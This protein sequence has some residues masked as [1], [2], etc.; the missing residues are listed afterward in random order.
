MLTHQ[1]VVKTIQK[2]RATVL[3]LY[4]DRWLNQLAIDNCTK[5][6]LI[7]HMANHTDTVT[8]QQKSSILNSYND[9]AGSP[10][11]ARSV[12]MF[13][14]AFDR[15]FN[16]PSLGDHAVPL[17]EV[18]LL[19]GPV[20]TIVDS[21]KWM[22]E[23]PSQAKVTDEHMTV[24]T[25][26]ETYAALG[27]LICTGSSCE[28]GDYGYDN[29][30]KRFSIEVIG[31]LSPMLRQK[32][33][34][35]A[36]EHGNGGLILR[37]P[38]KPCGEDCF[39]NKRPGTR[40]RGWSE[41]ETMIL[42][43]H[44]MTL[45]NTNI[46]VQCTAALT[47]GR[48]CWDVN[49]QLEKIEFSP[50]INPISSPTSKVKS[51][52]WYDRWKKMLLNDWQEQTNTHEHQRKDHFD[53]CSHDGPC[54]LKNCSCVQNKLMCERFC[55]CTAECC[56]YK[57][58]GCACHSQGKTC[59]S[60]Q[61]DRPCICIQLNRECDPVLCGS[62]GAFERANPLYADS[63]A[64]HATGCQNCA[65]Q[66]GKSKSVVLG[67]S[68]VAGY[69]LYTTEDIAQDDF[70]IE[71]VGEL[72]SHDE[73]VRREARRGDVFDESSNTSYLFTLLEQEGT[74][75]DAAIYGN[76]SRYI[77]HQDSNC[78]VTPRI[79]YVNGEYRIKFS[80]LRDI[81]A[82]EELFFNYGENFPNLTKKLLEEGEVKEK[83]KRGRK[84]V[85]KD[86]PDELEPGQERVKKKPGRKPGKPGRPGR[87]PGR[88]PGRPKGSKTKPKVPVPV[89][90]E[91]EVEATI[92]DFDEDLFPEAE[93]ST[94]RKRK[95][96]HAIQDSEEEEYRPDMGE[97][98]DEIISI[99]AEAPGSRGKPRGRKRLGPGKARKTAWPSQPSKPT[100]QEV[101][102]GLEVVAP[103][104]RG[105]KA[106]KVEQHPQPDQE[107]IH[108]EM[109]V[110][111]RTGHAGA[112][113][114]ILG[115]TEAM[116]A[117]NSDHD[118][119]AKVHE[120]ANE[121][122]NGDDRKSAVEVTPSR[123]NNRR[124]PREILESS[125]LS[126]PMSE[127]EYLISE[128][129][130]QSTS[131]NDRTNVDMGNEE[132]TGESWVDSHGARH[133]GHESDD[134]DDDDE[135]VTPRRRHRRK[136]ARYID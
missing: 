108:G 113:N 104:R 3:L 36:S 129:D 107:V 119:H 117:P 120:K 102:S 106:R 121:D 9:D 5:S 85:I 27:C 111:D 95:R 37:K 19:D 93:A 132:Y 20:D 82:G 40:A 122:N 54:T 25:F 92:E 28:H 13:T 18:L 60:K 133:R 53:P 125:P 2:E 8:P 35:R 17:R 21:K 123:G 59:V 43:S 64:L 15:V 38:E 77:N 29:E 79:L 42:K 34:R 12:R 16:S 99:N 26:L 86:P 73:G 91:P 94:S 115:H 7:R 55:L 33:M 66:R 23:T 75:V 30:R 1:K 68:K 62:C 134:D 71:Y 44:L 105:R 136:P 81:K 11:S 96:G 63:D 114:N 100:D 116:F 49:R 126:T 10:R 127:P 52:H 110:D 4:L 87:K 24:E 58:T 109:V 78:N 65:M 22:K 32:N 131:H 6:T 61:K 89:E 135:V 90:P 88:K 130:T 56:A 98:Q 46:P 45:S 101:D 50:T 118:V 76:L 47:T 31:G 69:G 83:A 97:S 128:Y 48:P 103:K 112:N 72:I 41:T 67:K 80:S 70:V 57:F 14:E 74:W 124:Q 84:K 39:L 51:L